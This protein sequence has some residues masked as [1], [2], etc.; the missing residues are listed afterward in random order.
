MHEN[1]HV[2][3]ALWNYD[4]SGELHVDTKPWPTGSKL[5]IR[6]IS[7]NMGLLGAG[8]K[9]TLYAISLPYKAWANIHKET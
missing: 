6:E 8:T 4:N 2:M 7:V 5:D 3:Q 9:T 1:T